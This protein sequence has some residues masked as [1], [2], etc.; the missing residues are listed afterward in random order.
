MSEHGHFEAG[1]WIPDPFAAIMDAIQQMH[2]AFKDLADRVVG[3][4]Q[5]TIEQ[6]IAY[7]VDDNNYPGTF[8]RG[9]WR[10]QRDRFSRWILRHWGP[11]EKEVG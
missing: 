1:I 11:K 5:E 2:A 8:H 4:M 9:A 10:P 6:V 7:V 3:W